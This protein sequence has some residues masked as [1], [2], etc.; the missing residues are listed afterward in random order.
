MYRSGHVAAAGILAI[1]VAGV[2][3]LSGQEPPA[4]PTFR[5]GVDLVAVTATVQ[6]TDGSFVGDLHAGD[7]HVFENGV[8]QTLAFFGSQDVAVD[9]VLL[10]DNS[11]SMFSLLPAVQHAAQTLVD[12]LGPN[13]RVTALSFGGAIHQR[14]A[15]T[16]DHE[17]AKATIRQLT[18]GG[19]TPLY[20]AL[21]VALRTLT[22]PGQE[23]R[24]RALVVLTD[25][26]D[27]TSLTSYDAVLEAARQSSIAVYIVSM[28]NLPTLD[29]A[30]TAKRMQSEYEMRTLAADTG[31]RFLQK[32]DAENLDD[33][34]RS[35]ARELTHQYTLGYVPAEQARTPA[36]KFR[37][38]S[39]LVSGE[40]V[41]VRARRGY[42]ARY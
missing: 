2:A 10:I 17:Q 12:A 26:D 22:P 23:M 37:P 40:N 25:G 34:Y 30:K 5:S 15:P 36:R 8:P 16:T 28:Q 9:L 42:L 39:I 32:S 11:A 20:D 21:Y 33:A 1:I 4:V 13:D 3:G 35:I 31:A 6:R 19:G 27:T 18:S 24:R 29:R 41:V 14:I 38:I 7:F